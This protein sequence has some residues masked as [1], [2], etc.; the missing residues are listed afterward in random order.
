M[1]TYHNRGFTL[2]ELLVV[3]AIIGILVGMLLPAVQ[4]VREAARR[5]TCLNNL[6]QI[7]LAALNFESA[8]EVFPPGL[9]SR[10]GGY[11]I[12]RNE[13][14]VTPR[15]SD[16]V[17]GLEIGWAVYLL[18]FIEQGNVRDDLKQGSNSWDT[19]IGTLLNSEGN[20]IAGTP[21]PTFICSSDIGPGDPYNEAYTDPNAISS[22]AGLHAKSNY[23]GA[24][25]VNASVYSPWFMVSLNNPNNPH[26]SRDWGI[27]GI[28]SKTGMRDI[29]DGTSN[30]IIF[31]EAIQQRK[32]A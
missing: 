32:H 29:R 23:V 20:L 10:G 4:N 28:N 9:N 12:S 26:K 24:M 1:K 17:D 5:T 8:R 25:G 2:V 14:P 21:V 15:P 6:R 30:V 13:H 3:I 19:S 31:G 27:M 7:S 22:G 16:S 18:P 11:F